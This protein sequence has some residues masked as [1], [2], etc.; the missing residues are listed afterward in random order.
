MSNI[1][2]LSNDIIRLVGGE[3]NI[4]NLMHCAT[5]L[6]FKLQDANQANKKDLE[7]LDGVLS[8]VH[9][10]G[11][12]QVVIGS[13]VGA[14]YDQ[15]TKKIK[16]ND[17][18]QND[19][20]STLTSK[21][22]EIISGAFSPL[23]GAFAG[24]G[25]V[26]ALLIV[27]T[28]SGLL[29]EESGTY[30]ILAASA[31]A[32]FFFLPVLLG[33]TLS[34]KLG[35]NAYVGGAIGA[36]LLD[37][38]FTNL[39]ADGN[40]KSDFL[41]LPVLLLDYSSSVFPVFIG[42]IIFSLFEKSLK[43][44]IHKDLQI[45]LVPMLSLIVIVPLVVLLFG[46]IGVF[47]GNGIA[48]GIK[49][50]SA[51]SGILTGFV[52]GAFIPFV[53]LLGLHWGLIPI[54]L[55]NVTAGGDPIF[56]MAA[57]STF[58]QIGLALGVFL[59]AKEK[60]LKAVAG[61]SMFPALFAGVTEPIFYAINL[62]YRKTIPFLMIA[63]AI[64]GG[65]NGFFGVELKS[66]TF[67][68]SLLSI[69]LFSP[70]PQYIIGITAS[71]VIGLALVFIFGYETRN[72]KQANDE[73]EPKVHLTTNNERIMKKETIYS[74][75]Q[76]KIV[77]LSEVN[78]EV[79]SSLAMGKGVAIEP[80]VGAVY[81]PVNGIVSSLFPTNHAIG[82]K[83]ENGAEILIHIGI[84]TVKLEGKHFT[85]QVKQGDS[86]SIGDCLVKFDKDQILKEGF[87]LITPIIITNTNDY[88]DIIETIN[89]S[90]DPS[91]ELLTLIIS[92]TT[93]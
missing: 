24:A 22:F 19:N 58:A 41:G 38:N 16:I 52:I 74:P 65:L 33:I 12:F 91:E 46:P 47:V 39:L 75:L 40:T 88:M 37:P 76:G 45:F 10:G 80:S 8:V 7:Q 36:A 64:G 9:S 59:L 2:K 13:D 4:N 62:R 56:A 67:F 50:L 73:Q 87:N 55:A 53:I 1:E 83:S 3:E 31:N 70:M 34:K 32:V 85:P 27:L 25:M 79:F 26:K 84:D 54:N 29:S 48:A 61:S 60:N 49:F 5:R 69:P 35:A 43:K 82:I 44:I 72:D 93:N 81:S 66:F 18:S 71:F 17:N 92:N 68:H 6:R 51:H 78:D 20:N 86:I 57:G 77:A 89:S 42:I 30:H 28:M 11:Q 23:L 21:I 90:V 14:V 63:G 15:I